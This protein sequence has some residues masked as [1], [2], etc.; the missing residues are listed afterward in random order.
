M[1]NKKYSGYCAVRDPAFHRSST[2]SIQNVFLQEFVVKGHVVSGGGWGLWRRKFQAG[3]G[4]VVHYRVAR[5]AAET[6]PQSE[7]V[8]RSASVLGPDWS[9]ITSQ[10]R[11][12]ADGVWGP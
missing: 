10:A 8:S 4:I 9:R 12:A 11:N 7:E 5:A 6:S 1:G 2:H 3:G